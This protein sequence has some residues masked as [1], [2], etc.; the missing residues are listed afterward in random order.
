MA[1]LAAVLGDATF[2]KGLFPMGTLLPVFV[3]FL[4][5]GFANF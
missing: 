3:D 4:V 5:A 2:F 1:I